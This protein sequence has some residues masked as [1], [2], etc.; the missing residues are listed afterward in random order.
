MVVRR[1]LKASWGSNFFTCAVNPDFLSYGISFVK[2]ICGF[3]AV[4]LP[5]D[6]KKGIG[7]E[8]GGP[9]TLA[10]S[11]TP[12]VCLALSRGPSV[13]SA[14]AVR[15]SLDLETEHQPE[16]VFTIRSTIVTTLTF[17]LNPA[18]RIL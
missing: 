12:C 1:H 8:Y 15:L 5:G 13:L 6:L 16:N 11:G 17:K 3:L 2:F 14:Q 10:M 4:F 18:F 9:N 7:S